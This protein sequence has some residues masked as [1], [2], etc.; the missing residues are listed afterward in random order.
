MR[1]A[2][3]PCVRKSS[4]CCAAEVVDSP[5][6]DVQ[7]GSHRNERPAVLSLHQTVSLF[8][9]LAQA[10]PPFK[11]HTHR[12]TQSKQD[13]SDETVALDV[14]DLQAPDQRPGRVSLM[15]QK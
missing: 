5:A 3:E 4:R 13:L 11:A 15:G 10:Q 14:F 2:F 6:A 9:H 12:H 8:V 7:E 1:V